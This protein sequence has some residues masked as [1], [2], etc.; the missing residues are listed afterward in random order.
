MKCCN[1]DEHCPEWTV[2]KNKFIIVDDWNNIKALDL[3][4]VDTF[5]SGAYFE[6]NSKGVK[7]FYPN[8]YSSIHL[9]RTQYNDLLKQW[10]KYKK[11]NKKLF[12]GVEE[13]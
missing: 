3:E 2:L 13:N 7:L 1:Y 11:K 10:A 12:K 9:T 6:H 4:Y 5:L 8:N